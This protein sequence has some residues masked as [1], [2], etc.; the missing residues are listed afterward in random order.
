MIS[1]RKRNYIGKGKGGT[2]W[3]KLFGKT[4]GVQKP[5]Y[6]KVLQSIKTHYNNWDANLAEATWLVDTRR[7]AYHPGPT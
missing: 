7:F 5:N 4:T 2:V 3:G 6:F 1:S